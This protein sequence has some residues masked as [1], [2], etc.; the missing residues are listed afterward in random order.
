MSNDQKKKTF[1]D[2]DVQFSLQMQTLKI[3][4]NES[5]MDRIHALSAESGV[6]RKLDIPGLRQLKRLVFLVK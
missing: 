5:I 4:F 1:T 3:L 6:G 2:S